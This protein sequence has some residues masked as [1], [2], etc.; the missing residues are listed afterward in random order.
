MGKRLILPLI[1]AVSITIS[2]CVQF[3]ISD[4]RLKLHVNTCPC[5]FNG[6]KHNCFCKVAGDLTPIKIDAVH[7][8]AIVFAYE[9]VTCEPVV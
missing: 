8:V 2:N 9:Y 1:F 6:F 5:Y 7:F 3:S 4:L